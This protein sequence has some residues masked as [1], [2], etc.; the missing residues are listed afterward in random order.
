LKSLDFSPGNDYRRWPEKNT[1]GD[2]L[3]PDRLCYLCPLVIAKRR[4]TIP[5]QL[6]R[7]NICHTVITCKSQV[8]SRPFASIQMSDGLDGVGKWTPKK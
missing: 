6:K 5:T 3:N 1:T 8:L 2:L 7:L 4:F